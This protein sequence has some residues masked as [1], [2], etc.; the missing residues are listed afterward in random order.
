MSG[1]QISIKLLGVA[2][3]C[4]IRSFSGGEPNVA[5]NETW[6]VATY[7]VR[8]YLSMDRRVRDK[9]RKDYPKVEAEKAVLR[10]T[11]LHAR[12]D[13]LAL[14]EVGSEGHL[15]ELQ[16]DLAREGLEYEYSAILEASD[17]DRRVAALWNS[18][19]PFQVRRHTDLELVYF[20]ETDHV[21]RGLLEIEF[22]DELGAFSIFIVHLKSKYT[23]RDDDP[24]STKRRTLE[25][26]SIRNRIIQRYDS[27]NESRF[28]ITGDFNDTPDSA[29]IRAFEK[30]GDL[31]IGVPLEI[32]DSRREI[33]TH[34]YKK[35][36][37]YSRVD[38]IFRSIGWGVL[39]TYDSG[40]H[41]PED[42]YTGSDHRLLFLD[43]QLSGRIKKKE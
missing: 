40:I 11:L 31:L 14:Q 12:A 28:L 16:A 25:A 39:E 18:D 13:F 6:R 15:R 43:L 4:L 38:Y 17:P 34:F 9:W 2:F 41:D 42:F 30:K 21:K 29:A 36:G 1:T 27:P 3:L 24:L 35:G 8:N 23:N 7:N 32:E 5:E 19:M 26:R 22:Q 37:V 20:G 33:W 10:R